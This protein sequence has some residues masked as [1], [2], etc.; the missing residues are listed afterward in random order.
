MSI[1]VEQIEII[2]SNKAKYGEWE[3]FKNRKGPY[4]SV[5]NRE[6]V[7]DSLRPGRPRMDIKY[8]KGEKIVS[9]SESVEE[10]IDL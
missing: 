10:A 8:K 4:Q 6:A 7:F 5:E 9:S 1:R 3:D 2:F